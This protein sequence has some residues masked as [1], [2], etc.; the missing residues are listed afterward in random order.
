[1]KN[2][3]PS[4]PLL[5]LLLLALLV[6]SCGA[7]LYVAWPTIQA[8]R[9]NARLKAELRHLRNENGRLRGLMDT[10]ANEK[11]PAPTYSL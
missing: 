1:M 9:E 6:L 3:L 5:R 10:L 4:S 11:A 8:R 7:S 2:K